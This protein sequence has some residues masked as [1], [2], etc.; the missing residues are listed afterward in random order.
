M[1]EQT[2]REFLTEYN[3]NNG[4]DIDDDSLIETMVYVGKKVHREGI[5]EHRWYICETVVNEI[6]GT[7][8]EFTDYIITGDNSMSDMDLEYDLDSA[9]IVEKKER[10]VTEIYYE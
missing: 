8:I 7:Y 2:V 3:K 6:D 9:K 5:D 10:Q 1:A 4:Y